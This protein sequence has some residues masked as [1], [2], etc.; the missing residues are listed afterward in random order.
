[1]IMPGLFGTR[2]GARR[3]NPSADLDEK[4]LQEIARITGGRYFRATNTRDLEEIYLL[5][6]QLEPAGDDELVFRPRA[7]LAHWPLAFAF[8]LSALIALSRLLPQ[9]PARG[10]RG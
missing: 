9:R 6:D 5:L 10:V 1:M 8:V 7:S 4:S 2:L 3:V